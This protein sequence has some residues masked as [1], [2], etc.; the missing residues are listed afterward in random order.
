MRQQLI[1]TVMLIISSEV[2]SV[3]GNLF[4]NEVCSDV[5]VFQ[6]RIWIDTRDQ[7]NEEKSSFI[8]QDWLGIMKTGH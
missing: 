8:Q 5:S 7:L 6:A 4:P 2:T 1:V 3:P